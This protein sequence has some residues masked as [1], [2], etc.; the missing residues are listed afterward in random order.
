MRKGR[1]CGH[2]RS[3]GI[4]PVRMGRMP[5][6]RGGFLPRRQNRAAVEK[7]SVG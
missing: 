7:P 4:L 2:S 5:M 1:L 6:L 3:T